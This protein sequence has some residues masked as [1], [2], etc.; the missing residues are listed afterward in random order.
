MRDEVPPTANLSPARKNWIG[1]CFTMEY[2]IEAVALFNP[3]IVPALD[4]AGVPAG[5]KRFVMSLRATGEGHISAIVFRTG[6]IDS[7]GDI[8]FDAPGSYS[9]PLK[10]T[11]PDT[12][13]KATFVRD[14]A[15]VGAANA[16]HPKVLDRLGETFTRDELS[17]AIESLR[18]EE[19]AS[20]SLEETADLL[21]SLTRANHQ[22]HLPGALARFK[23]AELVIFPFSD[24]ERHGIEDLRLVRFT[25]DDGSQVCSARS[26]PT[27][28]D[29][30]FPSCLRTAEATPSTSTS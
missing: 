17:A 24:I 28:E 15:M 29:G 23:E 25:D 26:R 7:K 30:F 9:R 1:A 2:A 16:H 13:G 4:Q 19:P 20:G 6:T 12:F 11:V 3:S 8:A 5:S 22:L 14:L 10:A 21:I 27:T 18:A